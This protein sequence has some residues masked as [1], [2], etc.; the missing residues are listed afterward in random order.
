MWL[1]YHG[2]GTLVGRSAIGQNTPE[3]V[4]EYDFRSHMASSVTACWD[5]RDEKL[6]YNELRRLTT[7]LSRV[8]P[9][10]LSDFYPLTDYSLES[11]HW[12]GWQFNRPESGEAIVQAFRRESSPESTQ[13]WKLQGLDRNAKYRLEALG[14]GQSSVVSG[15]SLLDE[16][17][18]IELPNARSAAVYILSKQSNEAGG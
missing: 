8:A 11:T 3:G 5:M 14:H 1:P 2:T 9:F 17:L 10:Y 12:I 15:T 4:S 13:T 7:E 18:R 6:D 16:G